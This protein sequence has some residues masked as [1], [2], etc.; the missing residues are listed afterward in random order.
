MRNKPAAPKEIVLDLSDV[1]Q[2]VPAEY[3]KPGPHD[4]KRQVRL[5]VS[6]IAGDVAGG[7]MSMTLS[8]LAQVC[9]DIFKPEASDKQ[10]VSVLFPMQKIMAQM[11][12]SPKAG[13]A[14]A[15]QK[16]RD[17]PMQEAAF[18]P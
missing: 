8:R 7:K 16:D 4:P 14:Q 3:I 9:P 18:P 15:E 13:R 5:K 2:R 12:I 17:I 1:L 10:D 6:E 11:A